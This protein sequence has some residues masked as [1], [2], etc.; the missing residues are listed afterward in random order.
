MLPRALVH[1][2]AKDI[3]MAKA[4]QQF[5]GD[6][7]QC[8]N[9]KKEEESETDMK[10][11]TDT[12]AWI[13]MWTELFRGLGM[14]LSYLFWEPATINY[15]FEKGP[16]SPRFVRSM[17]CTATHLWRS[18]A[19]PASSVRPSVLHKPSP[20]R[21]RQEPMAVTGQHTMIFT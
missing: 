18:F 15:A 17:H 10:S 5:S 14:T 9:M 8:V 19:L 1:D 12:A 21:L 3:L 13:L 7:V 6:N 20:L 16:L 4:F 11:S 2:C